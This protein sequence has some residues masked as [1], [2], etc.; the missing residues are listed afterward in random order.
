MI[1][2]YIYLL[3][4]V[5]VFFNSNYKTN[6]IVPT[7]ERTFKYATDWGKCAVAGAFWPILAIRLITRI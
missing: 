4:S 2:L 5:V 3:V 1:F 6:E 7:D